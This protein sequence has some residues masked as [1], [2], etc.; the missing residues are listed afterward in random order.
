MLR[1]NNVLLMCR[2]VDGL[3]TRLGGHVA[4]GKYNGGAFSA[5]VTKATSYP[6]SQ[7]ITAGNSIVHFG[8][9]FFQK[10]GFYLS[11]LS[12]EEITNLWTLFYLSLNC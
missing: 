8:D 2:R 3:L 10:R 7:S 5:R 1:Q 4:E 9:V 12:F 11:A 6:N